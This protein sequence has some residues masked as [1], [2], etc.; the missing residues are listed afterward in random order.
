MKFVENFF[1]LIKKIF[2]RKEE[3]KMLKEPI[4]NLKENKFQE[5]LKVN[6]ED[7]DNK[8]ETLICEGDGLGI[9]KRMSS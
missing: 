4:T 6:I 8:V 3:V 1:D 5:L 7:K 9:K 2:C